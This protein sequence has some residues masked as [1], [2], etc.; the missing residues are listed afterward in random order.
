MALLYAQK[1]N[2]VFDRT[3]QKAL[4]TIDQANEGQVIAGDEHSPKDAKEIFLNIAKTTKAGD[5]VLLI[6]KFDWA[7]CWNIEIAHMHDSATKKSL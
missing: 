7:N 4:K 5:C 1:R 2:S 3:V 6:M